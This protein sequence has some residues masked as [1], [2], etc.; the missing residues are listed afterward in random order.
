V[1]VV[2]IDSNQRAGVVWLFYNFN[3]RSG[4][5]LRRARSGE[6]WGNLPDFEGRRAGFKIAEDVSQLKGNYRWVMSEVLEERYDLVAA[7]FAGKD[8]EKRVVRQKVP[9]MRGT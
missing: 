1:L 6:S 4:L 8:G 9:A 3:E 2:E 7:V 5:L